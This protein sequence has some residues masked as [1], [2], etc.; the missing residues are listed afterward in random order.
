LKILAILVLVLLSGMAFAA[1]PYSMQSIMFLQPDFVLSERVDVDDLSNYIKS[2]NS[3]AEISLA[4]IESPN[5]TAGFIVTAVRPNGQSKVWFDFSPELPSAMANQLR[6]SMESVTPFKAQVGVVVFAIN[7][8]LWGAPATDR[9]GPWP[10]EWKEA[11]KGRTD[12]METG[13]LVDLV[14]PSKAGT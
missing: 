9:K 1:K 7:V 5:P 13:D 14:W 12:P 2:I 4:N 6:S 11:M 3:A 10:L 8:T